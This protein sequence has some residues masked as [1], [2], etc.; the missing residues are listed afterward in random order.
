MALNSSET[1]PSEPYD[2]ALDTSSDRLRHLMG[3]LHELSS[4]SDPVRSVNRYS[5]GMRQLFGNQAMISIS[6]RGAPPGHYRV[7]RF[8]H[9][10]MVDGADLSFA[11]PKAPAVRGGVLGDL[12][13]HGEPVVCRGLTI[14]WDPVLEK[15][16][17]PYRTLLGIPV[18]DQGE[19]LNWVFFLHTDADHFSDYDVEMRVL[20][21]NLMGGITSGKR[22]SHELRQASAWINR[23][24]DEIAEL[25]RGLLPERLPQSDCY[26]MCVHY[27]TFERAGGDFYWVQPQRDEQ[28]TERLLL[29]VADASGHG[30]SA[31]VVVA[32]LYTLL[33]CY[34]GPV[35]RPGQ[36]LEYLDNFFC[37]S[38]VNGSFVTAFCGSLDLANYNFTYACAGHPMPLWS[39]APEELNTL[40]RACNVPLGV[41]AN[42][43]FVEQEITLGPGH[44]LLLYTDGITEARS[45]SGGMLGE[46]AL[47][48]VFRTAEGDCNTLLTRLRNAL[49][50]HTVDEKPV[51]DQL[52][53]VMKV[54]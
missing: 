34:S 22:I 5:A 11:G 48:S 13:D 16:L 31:A 21:A 2:P 37:A 49:L 18:Y 36:L 54:L 28:G 44:R 46:E 29:F 19:A 24:V 9:Q 47:R 35:E 12:I 25:Q 7:M 17:A 3:L 33:R 53:L 1:S 20:Q 15:Q 40:D 45:P 27:E 42:Q 50:S 10:Q 23:E 51:D 41:L 14:D 4:D 30:P 52:M 32:M 38:N 39:P 8:L 26:E 6:L 43:R